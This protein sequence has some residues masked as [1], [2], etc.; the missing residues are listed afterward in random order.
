M[1]SGKTFVL[2]GTLRS[3]GLSGRMPLL[4]V[5]VHSGSK[6]MLA[7]GFSW[8]SVSISTSFVPLGGLVSG[9]ANAR[10]RAWSRFSRWT[11]RVV[12]HDAVNTGSKIAARYRTSRGEVNEDAITV[13][14]PG[15]RVCV[16]FAR[17][18]VST[19]SALFRPVE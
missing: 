5:V 12:G 6:T 3:D 2:G 9:H 15:R 1:L 18:L 14:G 10:R 19:T 11:L 7:S 8:R 4:L 13:R 17:E 16:Y